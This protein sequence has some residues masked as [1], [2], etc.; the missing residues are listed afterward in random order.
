MPR[1][2]SARALAPFRLDLTFSDGTRGIVDLSAWIAGRSGVARALADP[3]LFRQVQVDREAGTV[4]W[5][6]G[7]DLDPDALYD[8]LRHQTRAPA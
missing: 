7:V 8:D 3:A 4:V 1:I 2:I 6:N 5:P